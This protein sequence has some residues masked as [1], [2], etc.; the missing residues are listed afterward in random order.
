MELMMSPIGL[1][2]VV[3]N[4]SLTVSRAERKVVF[5]YTEASH[6]LGGFFWNE[7]FRLQNR[8]S[9]SPS[10]GKLNY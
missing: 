4:L 7:S 3:M 2:M 8:S 5:E 1:M 9:A 6:V 10:L